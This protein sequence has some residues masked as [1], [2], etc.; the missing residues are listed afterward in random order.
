MG[1]LLGLLGSVWRAT[2]GLLL[3]DSCRF[4]PSCSHY[5]AE[6]VARRGVLVGMALAIWRVLRCNPLGKGGFDP[7]VH[8]RPPCRPAQDSAIS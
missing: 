2:F 5:A 7:V 8:S 4:T 6:V 3:P 1:A